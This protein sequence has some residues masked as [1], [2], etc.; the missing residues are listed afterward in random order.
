VPRA[1]LVAFLARAVAAWWQKHGANSE[2]WIDHGIGTRAC[3]WIDKVLNQV[4]G[5]D[6]AHLASNVT[7]MMDTLVRCGIP[8]A[9]A[10]EETVSTKL[11]E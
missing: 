9:A 11:R 1:G 10:L 8:A 2:F 5:S 3:D 4:K 7:A 6:A